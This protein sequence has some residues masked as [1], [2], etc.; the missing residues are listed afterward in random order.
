M[1]K[2]FT[3]DSLT[4]PITPFKITDNWLTR[5]LTSIKEVVDAMND[6]EEHIRLLQKANENISRASLEISDILE[7][8]GVVLT[9]KQLDEI[10]REGYYRKKVA[11]TLQEKNELVNRSLLVGAPPPAG[12]FMGQLV[13]KNCSNLLHEIAKDLDVKLTKSTYPSY[14]PNI[15]PE[16]KP[17]ILNCSDRE[18]PIKKKNQFAEALRAVKRME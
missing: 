12:K 2:R 17:I 3:T 9:K 15:K 7:N 14:K 4:T 16:I 5:E 6:Q 18:N 10:I 11:K 8:G 13:Q 1:T